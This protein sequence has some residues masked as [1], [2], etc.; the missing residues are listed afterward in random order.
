MPR[1]PLVKHPE[2]GTELANVYE[3]ILAM[4]GQGAEEGVPS[5]YMTSLGERPDIIDSLLKGWQN[6]FISGLLPPTI[7]QMIAMTIALQHDCRYCAVGTTMALQMMGV[8]KSV[9]ESCAS[10][11]EFSELPP[12]QRAIM[13]FALKADLFPKELNEKD[14]Q[15]LYDFGLSDGEIIEIIMTVAYARFNDFWADV[16]EIPLDGEEVLV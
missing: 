11:P 2:P 12:P 15:A 10:D 5:N 13:K 8:S 16:S 1:F 7:K 9:I 6:V 4:G 3:K 14:Y